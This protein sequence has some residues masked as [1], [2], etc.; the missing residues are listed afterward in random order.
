MVPGNPNTGKR[1]A[2]A[3]ISLLLM[4]ILVTMLLAVRKKTAPTK[5]PPLHPSTLTPQ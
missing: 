1:I 5:E 3:L 4:L 2:T